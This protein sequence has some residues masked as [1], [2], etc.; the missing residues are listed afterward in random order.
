VYGPYYEKAVELYKSYPDFFPNPDT[1]KICQGKELKK[2]RR[3]YKRMTAAG[4]IKRGHHRQGLAFGGDNIESNIVHT[5]ESTIKRS[6][7]T[8]EQQQQYIDEG[9]TTNSNYQI[10][11]IV[12]D[13]NGTICVNGKKYK[14]GLNELHTKVTNFQNEVIRWQRKVGLRKE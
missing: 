6:K 4:K 7:L 9:H 12:E 8:P 5:G 14:F 11:K 3:Q 2:K 13:P 1:S 10:A